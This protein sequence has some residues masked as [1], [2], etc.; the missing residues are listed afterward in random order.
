MGS[1][2]TLAEGKEGAAWLLS[3]EAINYSL[4]RLLLPPCS[5]S[6]RWKPQKSRKKAQ[7]SLSVV[8]GDEGVDARTDEPEQQQQEQQERRWRWR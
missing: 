6:L 4:T 7:A 2:F 8:A 5:L 3:Q 1:E